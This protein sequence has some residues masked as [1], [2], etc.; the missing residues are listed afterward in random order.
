[1][2]LGPLDIVFYQA[3]LPFTGDTLEREALGGSET[4][5]IYVAKELARLGHKVTVYC[6]CTREAVFNGVTYIDL[7]RIDEVTEKECDVFICSRYFKVFTKKLRARVTILWLHELV[8]LNQYLVFLGPK[9]D[10]IY[11]LSDFHCLHLTEKCP[12][13]QSKTR[14]LMNGIDQSLID[15][16]LR[17]V[18]N[19]KHKIMFTSRPE[20]GLPEALDIYEEL[21]D[22]RLEFLICTY[23][24]PQDDFVKALELRCQRRINQLIRNG[25]PV[26]TGNFTKRDLYRHIAESKVVIYPTTIPE[27]FCISAVEAQAC[28]TIYLTV[29]DFAFK[30]TVSYKGVPCGDTKAFASRLHTLLWD[31]AQRRRLEAEG[32]E[33]VKRYTWENAVQLLLSDVEK[34]YEMNAAEEFPPRRNYDRRGNSL[35]L[36][37]E[38][39]ARVLATFTPTLQLSQLRKGVKQ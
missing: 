26:R 27:I 38:L 29:D 14:K 12:E 37:S 32:R 17:T 25:Y 4:A 22:K 9:I 33:Y 2:P 6:H 23:V 8:G 24:F 15:E 34:Q 21:K 30:E 5:L 18:K 7:S 36:H 3:G 1:M 20:R 39:L 35:P 10:I 16:T 31:S 13:L 11:G 19:K 28:G